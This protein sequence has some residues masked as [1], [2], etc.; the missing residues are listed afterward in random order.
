[1][2][3]IGSFAFIDVGDANPFARGDNGGSIGSTRLIHI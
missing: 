3:A 2:S 1:M